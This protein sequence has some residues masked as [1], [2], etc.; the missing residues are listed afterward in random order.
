MRPEV[1]NKT[2][3]QAYANLLP[4]IYQNIEMNNNAKRNYSCI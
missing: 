3:F 1:K 4:N 2:P